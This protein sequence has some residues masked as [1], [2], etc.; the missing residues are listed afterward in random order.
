MTDGNNGKGDLIYRGHQNLKQRVAVD[1]SITYF[2]ESDGF[3]ILKVVYTH[4]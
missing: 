1:V 4:K 3:L 2:N